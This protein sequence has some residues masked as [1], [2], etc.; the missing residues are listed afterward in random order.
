MYLSSLKNQHAGCRR[1][2]RTVNCEED[3]QALHARVGWGG[4]SESASTAVSHRP[5][6]PR[7]GAPRGG[8]RAIL[9]DCRS[10]DRE[11]KTKFLAVN[12][13]EE[14]KKKKLSRDEIGFLFFRN[15]SLQASCD[16]YVHTS[17]IKNDTHPEKW[18]D[19]PLN[20]QPPAALRAFG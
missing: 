11:T 19:G 7:L 4:A 10:V 13:I 9:T 18:K 14:K 17:C 12:E 2:Q 8:L 16:I 5:E 6:F 20:Q 3:M 1:V 15:S